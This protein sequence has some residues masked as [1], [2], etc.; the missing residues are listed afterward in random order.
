MLFIDS[1]QALN[2]IKREEL[3]NAMEGFGIPRKLVRLTGLTTTESWSKAFIG[4]K[5]SRAFEV[6]TG[7]RLGDSLSAVLFNLALHVALK[8]LRVGGT[9]VYRTKQACAYADD[10][11][12]VGRNLDSLMEMFDTVEEKS[13]ALGLRINKEKQNI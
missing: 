5:T 7:V 4:G 2:R 11:A 10:I 3:L 6:L 12:I 9:I 8:K 1:Q 13:W